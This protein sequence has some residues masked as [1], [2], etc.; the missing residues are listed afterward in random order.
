MK[1]HG[2]R[3]AKQTRMN[4]PPL[5]ITMGCPAGIGPEIIVKAIAAYSS[6]DESPTCVVL[7]DRQILERACTVTG[8]DHMKERIILW[9]PGFQAERGAINLLEVTTLT[10]HDIPFG[11]ESALT[12]KSAYAYLTKAIE[13]ALDGSI[14]GIVTAPLSKA[15]LRMAGVRHPGH[16]EILAEATGTRDYAMM[17]AGSR[18]RVALVTIHCALADVAE[19]L[20]TPEV[21]RLIKITDRALRE[22]FNIPA[23]RIAVAALNPHAGEGG[24]F[25]DE[26]KRII[27]PAVQEARSLAIEAS[28]PLP[29][30]TVFHAAWKGN[31]DA[32][33]CMYHDQGLIPFKLVH[34]SDGVNITLG[35]PVIRTSVDHGTA[36][37]IAG[38]GKAGSESLCAAISMASDF[39]RNL[40]INKT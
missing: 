17:L 35:L 30:D 28:G 3:A 29:P 7:G 6:S 10:G 1:R 11:K 2:T 14:A 34:F 40:N 32:V 20:S 18:L 22:L 27:G 23:P 26:E 24:M 37:D 4:R 5:G 16:T 19:A 31:F 13:L 33:V 8:L 12:G 39:D 21:L 25:G 38:T 36:Y 9:Q 15:G